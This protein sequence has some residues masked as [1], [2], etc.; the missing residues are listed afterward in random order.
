VRP[1]IINRVENLLRLIKGLK[2]IKYRRVR[3]NIKLMSP[4]RRRIMNTVREKDARVTNEIKP[5]RKE[6]TIDTLIR[7]CKFKINK[8]S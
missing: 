3:T 4:E 7:L 1:I 2:N 6:Y 8:L 5:K